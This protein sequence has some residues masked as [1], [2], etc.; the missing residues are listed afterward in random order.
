MMKAMII[1]QFGGP[2]RL[3]FKEIQKP[4]PLDHEVLIRVAYAGVNPVDWKIREGFL[5]ERLPYEFPMILGWDVSGTIVEVG[6]NV[7]N[8]KV[9]DEVYSYARKPLAKWGTYAEYVAVSAKD[10]AHKPSLLTFAE[11]SAVPLSGLTAWQSLFD[12]VHLKKGETLLILGG[13]G[14]VG[15]FAIQFAKWIGAKVMAT[16]SLKKHSYIKKLGAEIA[17]DHSGDLTKQIHACSKEG[18]DVV[19]DCFGKDAFKI[20]LDALKKGGRIVSVLEHLDPIEAQK[21]EISASY[22]FVQPNGVQLKQIAGLIDQK[23]VV[24][25]PIEEMP[26]KEAAAAQEKLRRGDVMGKLV[27]KVH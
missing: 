17:L 2:E 18:V 14:G 12:S 25:Q 23:K 20:G 6:K 1:D 19:F 21:R 5:K 10:V 13:S 22:V 15:S 24:S 7:N 11:A 16:A 26:L 27:L 8:L 3:H 4:V 9:G